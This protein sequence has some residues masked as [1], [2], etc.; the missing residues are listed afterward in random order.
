[1]DGSI[2]PSLCNLKSDLIV[3]QSSTIDGFVPEVVDVEHDAE[4]VADDEHHDHA[5]QDRSQLQFR[6]SG[7]FGL[8]SFDSKLGFAN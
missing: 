8:E 5:E 7:D 4:R 2:N 6:G 1:M 3:D